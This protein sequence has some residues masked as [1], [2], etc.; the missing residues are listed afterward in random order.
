LSTFTQIYY[1]IVFSTKDRQP[2]LIE[3]GRDSLFRYIWG[4]VKRRQSRLHRIN[5]TADHLHLFVSLHPEASLATL[6]KDIKVGS[7]AWI[8]SQNLFP[9]FTY[10]QVGYGAFTHS[11]KEKECLIEYIKRQEE[12]HSKR[13]FLEE[14]K[15][16]LNEAM[17]EYDEQFL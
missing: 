9:N 5:G 1:H 14:F 16:L 12:H 13:S 17:I 3:S 15:A 10:W 7:S 8:R 6:V 11:E 2:V 4:I